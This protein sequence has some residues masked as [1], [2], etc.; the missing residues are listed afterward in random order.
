M[1]QLDGK[2]LAFGQ[3]HDVEQQ[4]HDVA[5]QHDAEHHGT[6]LERTV[7]Q[8]ACTPYHQ[9]AVEQHGLDQQ[10][11]LAKQGGWKG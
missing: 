7:G 9:S 3:Q 2:Q 10:L 1:Q 4:F 11:G 6:S 8:P 5:G